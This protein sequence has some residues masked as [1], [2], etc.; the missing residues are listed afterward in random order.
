MD[1]TYMGMFEQ[2]L[3]FQKKMMENFSDAINMSGKFA[4]TQ[5]SYMNAMES[6]GKLF[7][8]FLALSENNFTLKC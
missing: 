4:E 5:Q 6:Y 2:G 1:K 3:D 7:D 8:F